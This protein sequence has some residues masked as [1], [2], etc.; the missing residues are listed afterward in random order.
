MGRFESSSDL[1]WLTQ[2]LLVLLSSDT[3]SC[4]CRTFPWKTSAIG[5]DDH[6]SKNV[7]LSPASSSYVYESP[8]FQATGKERVAVSEPISIKT[9]HR[10]PQESFSKT[11]QVSRTNYLPF[12]LEDAVSSG[13]FTQAWP[14]KN[15]GPSRIKIPV[16]K[17]GEFSS[18]STQKPENSQSL[19]QPYTPRPTSSY[20]LSHIKHPGVRV[21]PYPSEL[22]DHLPHLTPTSFT[23]SPPDFSWNDNYYYSNWPLDSH[24]INK[25]NKG[26]TKD[27]VDSLLKGSNSESDSNIRFYH[28]DRD[29]DPSVTSSPSFGDKQSNLKQQ[30]NR[31]SSLDHINS[32]KFYTLSPITPGTYISLKDP[33]FP[34]DK[35]PSKTSTE[36]KDISFLSDEQQESK[37]YNSF[38]AVHSNSTNRNRHISTQNVGFS[39]EYTHKKYANNQAQE[40]TDKKDSY[41]IR[42]YTTATPEYISDSENNQ[43]TLSKYTTDPPRQTS[44]IDA[45]HLKIQTKISQGYTHNND[46]NGQILIKSTKFPTYYIAD[47]EKE[48]KQ[49]SKTYSKV[50]LS[51]GIHQTTSKYARVPL[52]H[53]SIRG[54]I[55]HTTSKYTRVPP[56]HTSTRESI[57]H[58]TSKYTRVPS[59]HTSTTG[60]IH[61]VKSEYTRAPS[62]HI[63]TSHNIH[64]PTLHYTR[65][66]PNQTTTSDNIHQPASQYTVA[67]PIMNNETEN[68]TMTRFVEVHLKHT[69]I[70]REASQLSLDNVNIPSKHTTG[71]DDSHKVTTEYAKLYSQIKDGENDQISTGY[72]TDPTQYITI[73]DEYNKL[74]TNNFKVSLE[75]I[76]T[77]DGNDHVLKQHAMKQSTRTEGNDQSEGDKTTRVTAGHTEGTVKGYQ[78]LTN[79][80]KFPLN[81]SNN[82]DGKE[83]LPSEYTKVPMEYITVINRNLSTSMKNT[84][85]PMQYKTN[86]VESNR[87]VTKHWSTEQQ[88]EVT[89]P[90]NDV[91]SDGYSFH[92]T[93]LPSGFTDPVREA[94]HTQSPGHTHT[95]GAV[96]I[97][98]PNLKDVEQIPY[99]FSKGY[100]DSSN[101]VYDTETPLPVGLDYTQ[102][103]NVDSNNGTSGTQNSEDKNISNTTNGS[104][105]TTNDNEITNVLTQVKYSA[106]VTTEKPIIR[107]HTLYGPSSEAVS[108]DL[109]TTKSPAT[110]N[111]EFVPTH[112]PTSTDLAVINS[113]ISSD[114]QK[115]KGVLSSVNFTN[116]QPKGIRKHSINTFNNIRT[117]P[118][119]PTTVF[120]SLVLPGTS[121]THSNTITNILLRVHTSSFNS[122]LEPINPKVITETANPEAVTESTNNDAV[123]IPTTSEPCV[124]H[125]NHRKSNLNDGVVVGIVLGVLALALVAVA[126]ITITYRKV[127]CYDTARPVAKSTRDESEYSICSS[128]TS[129]SS[130][131]ELPAATSEEMASVN[132]EFI[133]GNFDSSTFKK[134]SSNYSKNTKV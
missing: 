41:I 22:R 14:T 5:F 119:F 72:S 31:E 68:K 27:A 134:Y 101:G 81:Q 28:R 132:S 37:T 105:P 25:A 115:P 64:Q 75:H 3:P 128:R 84:S 60:N 65:A 13:Y 8:Q 96:L 131:I 91:T 88:V 45:N 79:Y 30:N 126:V 34:N 112:D 90:T 46:N 53:T 129:S 33:P 121:K 69:S 61:Q 12:K 125:S 95:T 108:N 4:D 127:Y 38:P 76:I 89:A 70:N 99:T 10:R 133:L 21:T 73:T 110:T 94:S 44:N 36:Y 7:N 86:T 98:T 77:N 130:H 118:E 106:I 74:Y 35:V 29:K 57:H 52:D 51:H 116:T 78:T 40:T 114:K 59:E 120:P 111:F 50:P 82:H 71:A 92:M 83:H 103:T 58:T 56:D 16:T 104:I 18:H 97:T 1:L 6:V 54:S 109:R 113:R 20:F 80:T 2:A 100:F 55:H 47:V 122:T 66:P 17:P 42:K 93:S 62:H 26:N 11:F 63:N 117:T 19:Y 48:E 123:T 9:S 49:T 67:P 43:H 102:E 107:E 39:P 24:T 87:M 85:V 23:T 32:K 15:K 124:T